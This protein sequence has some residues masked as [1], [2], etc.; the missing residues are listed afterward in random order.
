MGIR[1]S[2]DMRHFGELQIDEVRL[3][4]VVNNHLDDVRDVFTQSS[5]IMPGS[6][7]V[8]GDPN[9]AQVHRLRRERLAESGVAQR[10]NDILQWE[11]MGGGALHEQAGAEQS[12]MSRRITDADRRIDNILRDLQRREQRYFERFSRLEAAMMQAQSQ[13]MWLDQMMFAGMQ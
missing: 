8:P 11:T 2:S 13:M 12:V 9:N 10:I 1:T 7:T 6:I 4:Y 3:E 5:N